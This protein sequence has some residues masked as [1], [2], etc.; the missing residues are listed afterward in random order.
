MSSPK[1]FNEGSD[2]EIFA[3]RQANLIKSYF[4]L[5]RSNNTTH[6]IF[7][8]TNT[9]LYPDQS[10]TSPHKLQI[11]CNNLSL[12]PPIVLKHLTQKIIGAY[13]IIFN[14]YFPT[15]WKCAKVLPILK[16]G[17]N[18][19][20]PAS[21]RPISLT[22]AISKVFEAV[23]NESVTIFCNNDHIIRDNQFGFT[24]I[25]STTHAIHKVL[26]NTN[27]H[28]RNKSMVRAAILDVEKDFDSV[29]HNGLLL[30][31]KEKKFPLG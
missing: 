13:V 8:R 4:N 24:H 27:T 12:S 5:N 31:L 2:I 16:I 18:A 15:S 11:F 22:P 17:Q 20:D 25:Q 1:F 6:P 10:S 3:D 19:S 7:S 23:I 26:A 30:K 14:N 29:C 28:S 9:S 21:Y